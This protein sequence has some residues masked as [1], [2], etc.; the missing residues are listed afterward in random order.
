MKEWRYSAII[1][2]LG[3]RWRF[4]VSFT[5]PSREIAHNIHWILTGWVPDV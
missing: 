5:F 2:D 4:V 1:L 3:S